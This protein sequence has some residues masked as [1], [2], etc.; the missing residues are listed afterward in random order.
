MVLV[1]DTNTIRLKTPYTILD[2]VGVKH[3]HHFDFQISIKHH[4]I[5]FS[6][7]V[8]HHTTKSHIVDGV[9]VVWHHQPLWY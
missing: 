4:P 1:F 5:N 6:V 8:W 9:G 7:M 3:Q 2:G